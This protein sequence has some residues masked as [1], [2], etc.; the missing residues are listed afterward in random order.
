MVIAVFPLPY[1]MEA[2]MKGESKGNRFKR[3]AEKR[4]KSLLDSIRKLS[5]CANRRMYEWNDAQ[6]EKIWNAV[7]Q[8]LDACKKRFETAEP[9]EFTL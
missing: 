2:H 5:Q 1:N 3:V 7:E 9:D 8:E 4:V 6:L